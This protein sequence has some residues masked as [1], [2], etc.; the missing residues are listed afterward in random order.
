[1]SV[2]HALPGA[3]DTLS[4]ANAQPSE[5]VFQPDL[6]SMLLDHYEVERVTL[7]HFPETSPGRYRV[8]CACGHLPPASRFETHVRQANDA[9]A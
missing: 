9:R 7:K 4:A 8:R 3:Q 2:D 5:G 1:M 6:L